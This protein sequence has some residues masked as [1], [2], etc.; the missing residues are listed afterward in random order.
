MGAVGVLAIAFASLPWE[1]SGVLAVAIF[2]ILGLQGLRLPL[3]IDRGGMSCW[4]AWALW[5]LAL[6]AGPV[7]IAVVGT[8]YEWTGPPATSAPRPWA[9]R[10]VDSLWYAH[11]GVSVVASMAVVLI[12]R[13]GLRWIAWAAI[14][15]IGVFAAIVT[16]GAEMATTGI[17][18]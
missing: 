5:F 1:L 16:L 6:A 7:A 11:L 8:T 14:V 4:L 2:G 10:V 17:Y 3:V 12:V 18:L 13:Q 9:A 15:V